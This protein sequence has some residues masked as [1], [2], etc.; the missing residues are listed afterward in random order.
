MVLAYH[1]ILSAYGFWLPND[2]RGSWSDFVGAWDLF[3]A[4]GRA[5]KVD[6]T[7]SVAHVPHDRSRRLRTR[8]ELSR[9]PVRFDGPQART[10]AFGFARAAD[11]GGYAVH[12]CAVLPDHCHL[13][14][15]R[16]AR[17]VGR[18][19]GHL[20]ARATQA[21]VEDGLWADADCSPWARKGWDV[22]V[23]NAQWVHAAIHYVERNPEKDGLRRQHWSFVRPYVEK[24]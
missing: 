24:T 16:H 18:I 17:S 7:A 19:N 21:L 5:T 12:A 20:K 22:F 4:D 9:P 6:T 3:R 23:D 14:V 2:P 13:I 10:I 11:E 15:G 1:I 8:R